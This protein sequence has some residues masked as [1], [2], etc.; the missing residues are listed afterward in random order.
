M[1]GFLVAG[2]ASGVGKT[3]VT[4]ALIAAMRRR[5]LIVQPFKG[6]PDFLDTG[7]LTRM[8]GRAA[9]NL[10][11]WML[12]LSANKAVLREASK[13]ADVFVVEGMMG[14]FD[15]KD[16]VTKTGSSAEIAKLLQLPVVLVLDAAK[17]ARSI[18]AVVLGFEQFD[19]KLPLAGVILNRAASERHFKMLKSAITSSCKTPVLGWLPHDASI[20]IPERHLGLQAAEE[21]SDDNLGRQTDT[22]ACLAENSLNLDALLSLPCGFDFGET[23][24]VIPETGMPAVRIGVARDQAFSFYY[25]DNLDLLRKHGAEIVPFSPIADLELPE[26][27]DALYLGGGYPEVYAEQLS[28]NRSMLHSM[29]QFAASDRPIYAECGGMIYLSR[30]LTNLNGSSYGMAGIL[31]FSS[32]MTGKL[33][34]FGYV[35]VNLTHDCVLGASGTVLRGHSFHYSRIAE[36]PNLPTSYRVRYSL[37]DQQEEEGYRFGNVLVSYIHFHFRTAPH[38]AQRFVELTRLLKSEEFTTA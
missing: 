35:T 34:K 8:A 18:A 29:R 28:G 3:T 16:G 1:K 6:G 36:M 32:E 27:L 25:E 9:R 2:T 4:L 23:S 26:G 22:L 13:G 33:E 20:A 7:H 37:S 21:S 24:L 10:D 30:Q 31:P 15:G 11:T 14:L 38:I 19:P 17:S 12:P 5:G